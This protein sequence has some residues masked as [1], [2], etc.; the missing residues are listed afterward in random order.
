MITREMQLN[1]D[2]ANNKSI[3]F[4]AIGYYVSYDG[5]C[6]FNLKIPYFDIQS[7]FQ[8]LKPTDTVKILVDYLGSLMWINVLKHTLRYGTYPNNY[9]MEA[10]NIRFTLESLKN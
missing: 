9:L 7:N 2:L 10:K 3:G 8:D 1:K 4:W 6:G 5:G